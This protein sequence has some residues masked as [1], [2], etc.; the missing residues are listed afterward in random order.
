M[1]N[2][3]MNKNG[4]VDIEK[5][6]DDGHQNIDYEEGHDYEGDYLIIT[7]KC[8]SCGTIVKEHWAY[9]GKTMEHPDGSES[10]DL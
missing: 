4:T 9:Q 5:C 8:E 10:N 3:L 2:E 6:E 1:D 7:G